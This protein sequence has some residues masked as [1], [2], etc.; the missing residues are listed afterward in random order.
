[1]HPFTT[2][3]SI[4]G[5]Y[6]AAADYCFGSMMDTGKLMGLAPYG[7]ASAF[8]EQIFDLRD[9]RTYVNY[10]WT[11][12]FNRPSRSPHDFWKEF[13]YYANVACLV[14][15]ETE[16]AILY[17][18]KSR[19][20]Y[21]KS[22][23]LCYTGGVALNA[24]ANAK[25]QDEKIFDRIFFTPAAGDNGL[26]I[27]CAYFGWMNVL[28]KDRPVHDGGSCF[29][30]IYPRAQIK[31]DLCRFVIPETERL[32]KLIHA[33]FKNV[34]RFSS[35]E[36]APDEKYAVQFIIGGI[37]VF[38][39]SSIGRSLQLVDKVDLSP[40]C[41]FFS[42]GETFIE[43][44]RS[45][46]VLGRAMNENRAFI[47][48]NYHRFLR[49]INRREL[50]LFIADF[51]TNNAD[52]ALEFE[53]NEDVCKAAARLLAEGNVIGWFQ[54]GSEFGPRAL[55]HRSILADPR[56]AGVQKFINNHIKRRE[57]FRPFAPAILGEHVSDYFEA[58]ADSPYMLLITKVKDSHRNCISGV[59]HVDGTSRVQ[60]V[61]SGWNEKFYTL[62]KEFMALTGLPLLLNTSLN[63]KGM[64][65]VE[66][67]PEAIS[68]F[69]ESALDYLV[70]D[71]YIIGKNNKAPL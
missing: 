13:Q 64:P 66:T 17:L 30:K 33:F 58:V 39:V 16:R 52:F 53:E 15:K 63:R 67:P 55:G 40:D 5:V 25:M 51:V 18:I 22:D 54:E 69:F 32:K 34:H 41:I 48:G 7:D 26:A 36:T 19:R 35:K 3:H 45:P 60:T 57:D 2:K 27:G 59:V 42:E 47:K 38:F 61:T 68:F 50:L 20:E 24:M 62:L 10:E 28:N 1:M 71:N 12:N 49:Q 11:R 37:G 56:K 29:G 43:S 31:E 23:N 6:A 9:G 46:E 44:F 8:K 14:Q 65:I 4:G 21:T 70:I